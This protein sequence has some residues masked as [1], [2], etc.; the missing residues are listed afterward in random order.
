MPR[1]TKRRT[2]RKRGRGNIE[3][4][5][6][7]H[8]H[9]LNMPCPDKR[10]NKLYQY[11]NTCNKIKNGNDKE[12]SAV[13]FVAL[14]LKMWNHGNKSNF[15]IGEHNKKNKH[16][17]EEILATMFPNI[18]TVENLKNAPTPPENKA[19]RYYNADG[20]ELFV[21]TQ[22]YSLAETGAYK[23]FNQFIDGKFV[24]EVY[25]PKRD[26]YKHL[27][28]KLINMMVARKMKTSGG[29]RRTRRKRRKRKRSRRR[30]R[31]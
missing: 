12:Q 2:R 5:N 17:V 19:Y 21:E 6:K 27:A 22:A 24:R 11:A 20:V 9:I 31:K 23:E 3:L 29:K 15:Q 4:K 25:I 18:L 16:G 28:K 10:Y 1:K 26:H 14:L 8:E 7:V 30:R 13:E